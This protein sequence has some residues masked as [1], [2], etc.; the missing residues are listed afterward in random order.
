LKFLLYYVKH[1]VCGFSDLVINFDV[2][3]QLI[4]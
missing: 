1:A 4:I 3:Q 2:F